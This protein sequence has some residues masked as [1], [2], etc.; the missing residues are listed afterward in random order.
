M[1]FRQED[2]GEFLGTQHL[3]SQLGTRSDG[4]SERIPF[5]KNCWPPAKNLAPL[6]EI[7]GIAVMVGRAKP[8]TTAKRVRRVNILLVACNGSEA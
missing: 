2:L 1:Q 5:T 8:A 6:T 3:E 4:S 7:V